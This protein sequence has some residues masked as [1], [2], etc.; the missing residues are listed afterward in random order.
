[1]QQF[2]ALFKKEIGGY[3]KS[4]FAYFV[5]F[6]YL[7]VSIGGAFY[8]GAY[9]AM[10]D[11]AV[12]ALFYLQP[13]VL[14]LLI[15]ALTMRL[16][17]DEYKSGTA[18][19]LLTQPVAD[20]LM[21]LAKFAAAGFFAVAMSLCLLPFIVYT[22][23]WLKIDWGNIFC[24]Y[25]GTWLF[26]LLFC[27]LG[28]FIS[29]L[30]KYTVVSYLLTVFVSGLW[31]LM[32]FTKLSDIYGNFLFAEIGFSDLLYFLTFAVALIWLNVL[33]LE[34]IRSAQKN[35]G[36]K[37]LGF[38]ALFIVGMVA[39]NVAFIVLFDGYKADLTIGRQYTL[40]PASRDIVK[41]V[42]KPIT[43]DVYIS[44]DLKAKNAEY[45]YYYQQTKR[46]IEKYQKV[47]N[48][49]ISVNMVEVEPFSEMEKIVLNTG[50]YYEENLKG[51]KDY[52][53]AVI[54]DNEGQG[55]VIKQFL[56][57]RRAFLEKDIDKVLLKLT[58]KEVIKT[59]GIYYDPRQDL[60]KFNGF[61]LNLEEDYNVL[62]VSEDTYE[63]SSKLDLLILVNPKELPLHFLYAV[64]QYIA[65]GGNI[66][67][68]FDLLTEG[69]S[70]ETNLKTP[71][72][73]IFMDQMGVLLKDELIDDG[74]IAD[75]YKVSD[76]KINI[77]KALSFTV[78][79]ENV[80]VKPVILS[81]D[82]YIAALISGQYK[83]A[84]EQNPHQSKEILHNMMPHTY[85][86]SETPNVVF[87]GDADIIENETWIDDSSPDQNP[88]SVVYKS[89]NME[90]IRS[91]IDEM[92]GN[93]IY[94]ALPQ[95]AKKA[96]VFGI[97]E[98]I[99]AE[100]Y[101]KYSEK[102]NAIAEEMKLNRVKLLQKSG[103]DE[104]KLQILLQSDESGLQLGQSEQKM[105]KLLYQVRKQYSSKVNGIIFFCVFGWPLVAGLL[106]WIL[107]LRR[108]RRKRKQIREMFYE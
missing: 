97:G 23:T 75:G 51:T 62:S 30:S 72:A 85:Y 59:I 5:F 21:V 60:D 15:P 55:E 37:F 19:F 69:Q 63:I 82:G 90:V 70:E 95:N 58:D 18:E 17:S 105:E 87:V 26:I 108:E 29:S 71:Q 107:M 49:M 10:H 99:N 7:F 80:K 44:K 101:D 47:S 57:Q 74:D 104:N 66:I 81:K 3:F 31:L 6:I 40:Q 86:S 28:C 27:A 34:Y 11:T 16:W 83:S 42:N 35:K 56:P 39:L 2:S 79:D 9:L 13:V 46:F 48:S 24:C 65:N 93:D 20:K 73:V 53:G 14:T 98:Q 68:F 88:Y 94:N 45:Y 78:K 41:S 36:L 64:D 52:F 89:A 33:V 8:F 25:L 106:S 1:M 84:F 77:Y 54:R 38:S 32:P 50:M 43:I 96:S 12:Y 22:A 92:V 102:L 103:G 61:S 100:L 91:L 67:M 4:S 76:G